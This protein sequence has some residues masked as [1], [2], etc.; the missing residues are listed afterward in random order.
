MGRCVISAASTAWDLMNDA[1][2]S[3]VAD[4]P[5]RANFE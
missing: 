3:E 4:D 1:A 2:E 5:G